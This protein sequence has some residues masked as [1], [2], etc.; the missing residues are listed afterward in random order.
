MKVDTG[1]QEL[2]LFTSW[3]MAEIL[4]ALSSDQKREMTSKQAYDFVLKAEESLAA[5]P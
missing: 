3:Y 2:E 4:E 1:K 5:H